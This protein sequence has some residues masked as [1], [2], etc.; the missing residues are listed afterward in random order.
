MAEVSQELVIEG[1]RI[2]AD[3]PCYI[4]VEIG[5]THQGSVARATEL[6][7][8][9]ALCGVDAVKLQRK[10]VRSLYAPSLYN[11][12]YNGL[13]PTY[14]AHKDVLEFTHREIAKLQEV[15]QGNGLTLFATPF[16]E[17]SADDLQALGMP[18]FKI[19]SGGLTDIRLLQHVAKFEKPV[20]LSTGG[21]TD[22]DILNAVE[23]LEWHCPLA[24][25]HCCAEYPIVNDTRLNL[26]CIQRLASQYPEH[27]I[28]W[29]AHDVASDRAGIDHKVLAYGLGAR[30]IEVHFTLDH[31]LK[32]TDHQFSLE[33]SGLK[34]LVKVLQHE[35]VVLGDGV[36]RFY[37]EERAGIAKMRR[38]QTAH[39]WQIT[40]E[41]DETNSGAVRSA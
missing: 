40:G 33:P 29:S 15:A 35:R 26:Q 25:L 19:H 32:G 22:N 11:L 38:R 28:G 7:E 24:I 30:I 39:G 20:I 16:D 10:H 14:G 2:A 3:E 13:A 23:I 9:A 27:V 12:E 34:K 37:P 21:G 31:E 41:L 17:D 5:N 18:C 8:V 4:V 6:I 1:R 36:K